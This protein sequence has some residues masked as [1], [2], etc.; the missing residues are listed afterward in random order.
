MSDSTRGESQGQAQGFTGVEEPAV[1]HSGRRLVL[2]LYAVVV[3]I[4]GFTGF[5][6]GAIGPR[7]LDPE[8]FGVVQLPP[9]P[10]GM[11]AYGALTLATVLGVVLV[12]VVYVSDR[13]GE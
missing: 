5:V 4:A 10:V 8:L 9:T 11:A 1:G 13:Y 2:V 3:A 7:D 12:L 6:I